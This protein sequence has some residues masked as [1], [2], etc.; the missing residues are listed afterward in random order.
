MAIIASL[1]PLLRH[2][3]HHGVIVA[4]I[5]S[6]LPSLRVKFD[7]EASHMTCAVRDSN[8]K[9]NRNSSNNKSNRNGCVKVI[10][11]VV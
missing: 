10:V 2:C 11:M 1:W 4:I 3:G 7:Q 5:A 8:D 9:S 6:L